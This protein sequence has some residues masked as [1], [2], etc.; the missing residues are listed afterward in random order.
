MSVVINGTNGVTFN[1]GT[2]QATAPAQKNKIINGN[3]L[4]AQRAT[5][6]TGI[7]S[8]SGTYSTMDRFQDIVR[9]V[10]TWTQTQD[11]DVPTGQGFATSLKMD[12]TTA[13]GSLSADSWL[14]WQTQ[15][16][17]FNCQPFK[18]GTAN[19]ESITL[20]FWVKSN[21][22]GTYCIELY[23][24]SSGRAISKSYTIDSANTYEKKELTFV[25]DT[26]GTINNDN[27]SGFIVTYWFAAGANYQSGTLQTSWGAITTANRAVGQV[28]LAD[29]TSNYINITG[30]QL[31]AGVNAT[32]FEHLQY[33]QQFALCQ[34][35]YQYYDQGVNA[36]YHSGII[37]FPFSTCMRAAPTLTL[38][39]SGAANRVYRLDTGATA[40]LTIAA[41]VMTTS[42]FNHLYA[43][44]PSGWASAAGVGFRSNFVFNAEF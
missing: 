11:T 37:G 26:V 19:A 17:G 23:Q 29:S 43:F 21:K 31:E 40:D 24:S 16:E 10:G 20:S 44:T 41:S 18:F 36:Y 27:G 42:G 7:T 12:C 33:G 25:G 3:M 9:T 34:R 28:N 32:D 8:S 35:Y 38:S 4:I 14:R 15:L 2:I 1:D 6:V 22:T 13:N 5:S 39:Y 30:L